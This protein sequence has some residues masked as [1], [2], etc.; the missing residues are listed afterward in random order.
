M[1]IAC[2]QFKSGMHNHPPTDIDLHTLSCHYVSA[3]HECP[4]GGVSHDGYLHYPYRG[5]SCA[6]AL[7]KTKHATRQGA[8]I[9]RGGVR[10]VSRWWW[11]ALLLVVLLVIGIVVGAV[12]SA[13]SGSSGA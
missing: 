4:T 7:R 10:G 13:R 9:V 1:S 8:H 5:Q 2:L 3:M 11:V 12:V 6:E